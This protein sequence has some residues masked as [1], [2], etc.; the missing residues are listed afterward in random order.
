MSELS[1]VRVWL[2]ASLLTSLLWAP[3]SHGQQIKTTLQDGSWGSCLAFSP[4]GNTLA[5]GRRDHA[6]QLWDIPTGSQRATLE[7]HTSWVTDVAFSQ[8]GGTLAS[9]SMDGTIR[10]WDVQRGQL[11]TTLEPGRGVWSVAFSPDGRVL[12]SGGNDGTV[13]LWNVGN[14]QLKT[15]RG[16]SNI[17]CGSLAFSPGGEILACGLSFGGLFLFDEDLGLLNWPADIVPKSATGP[18]APN[19]IGTVSFSP[20]GTKMAHG[21]Q[22]A[23]TQVWNLHS[24]QEVTV[25]DRGYVAFSPD[26]HTLAIGG[27]DHAVIR[28]WEAGSGQLIT[29]LEGQPDWITSIAFSADGTLASASQDG[30]ILLWDL[31]PTAVQ[32]ASWAAVKVNHTP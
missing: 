32:Q 23:R 17:F 29:A 26:G 2:G 8:D 6:I 20:D 31:S 18:V 3:A 27:D 13:R 12:A 15:R 28:L 10:L 7:A 19:G 5:A 14:A 25:P 16:R 11:E 1:P 9:G 30:T 24:G 21:R 4:S 22:D